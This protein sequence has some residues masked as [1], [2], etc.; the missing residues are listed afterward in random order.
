MPFY[1]TPPEAWAR[2]SHV[3]LDW[4]TIDSYYISNA[5]WN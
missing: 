1:F 2:H 5:R 4:R 3:C